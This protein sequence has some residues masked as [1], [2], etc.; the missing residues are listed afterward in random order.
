MKATAMGTTTAS[1]TR[2]TP[3]GG[4]SLSAG[5]HVHETNYWCISVEVPDSTQASPFSQICPLSF[6]CSVPSG[7]IVSVQLGIRGMAHSE[8]D[9]SGGSSIAVSPSRKNEKAQPDI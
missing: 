4:A 6:S 2:P 8:H 5:P 1:Q 7:C 9:W 3:A